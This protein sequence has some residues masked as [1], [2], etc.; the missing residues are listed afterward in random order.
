[1]PGDERNPDLQFDSAELFPFQSEQSVRTERGRP[2]ALV[3][4][5]TPEF[6]GLDQADFDDI[7]DEVV[8]RA[9]ADELRPSLYWQY[10]RK[11]ERLKPEVSAFSYRTPEG[12]YVSVA[13]TPAE[14]D[15]ASESADKLA[16]RVFNKVLTQRDEALKKETDDMSARARSDEDIRVAKRG[17]VRA[18]MDQQAGM[19][20]LLQNGVLPKIDLI[21]KFI[22]MTRGNNPNLARGS[23]QAVSKRFDE[24]RTAVFDDMLDAIALQRGWNGVMTERAKRI[25]QKR[26]YMSG[27]VRERIANFTEMLALAHDYYGYK[28]A[29]LLTKIE[30]AKRYQRAHPDV[31]ADIMAIDE[32]RR[33]TKEAKQLRFEDSA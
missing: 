12:E 31:V 8:A 32:E 29:L 26:L 27:H 10:V 33:R 7:P 22:E 19:E 14:Y 4:I 1:M 6:H 16:Q 18:V 20:A 5:L 2:T 24:L 13:L 21:E 17:S 28:R 23:R 9:T 11:G 15:S 25:I 30:D 3:H